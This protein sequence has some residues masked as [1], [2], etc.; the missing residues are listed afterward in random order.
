MYVCYTIAAGVAVSPLLAEY[1]AAKAYIA[2][3]SKALN[4]ELKKN[5]IHV[6]CQVQYVRAPA[7]CAVSIALYS[8]GR[9]PFHTRLLKKGHLP[10]FNRTPSVV[11]VVFLSTRMKRAPHRCPCS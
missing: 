5:N 11:I 1:G 6:Q 4:V 2:M 7:C 10:C 8:G 9:M 3:F